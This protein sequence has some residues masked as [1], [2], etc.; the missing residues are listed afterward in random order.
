MEVEPALSSKKRDRDELG[1]RQDNEHSNTATGETSTP[2]GTD[3]SEELRKKRKL[4]GEVAAQSTQEDSVGEESLDSMESE[5]MDIAPKDK[6]QQD[7][8][9]FTDKQRKRKRNP[10]ETEGE[11]TH[12]DYFGSKKLRGK[13]P[14]TG[15]KA[16]WA[17][18]LELFGSDSAVLDPREVLHP[19]G[20]FF[21]SLVAKDHTLAHTCA[22]SATMAYYAIPDWT[23][24]I[25]TAARVGDPAR[26]QSGLS[27]TF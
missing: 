12:T 17:Y 21:V 15:S 5:M 23:P 9:G 1:A 16:E 22:F 25:H 11:A 26:Y 20:F 2:N 19:K 13:T 14:V 18:Q 3:N 4:I 6:L 7:R 10:S 24:A 27:C 8:A